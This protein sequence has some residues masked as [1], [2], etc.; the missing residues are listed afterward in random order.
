MN[1]FCM[2][3]IQQDIHRALLARLPIPLP[4]PAVRSEIEELVRDAYRKRHEAARLEKEA[5]LLVE[6]AIEE[7]A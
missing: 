1:S 6:K 2:G 7:A 5:V 3:S 4:H